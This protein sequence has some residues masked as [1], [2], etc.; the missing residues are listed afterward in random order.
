MEN[1][2]DR[3][4]IQERLKNGQGENERLSETISEITYYYA[5][6]L[7][8]G[9]ILRISRTRKSVWATVF[10]TIPYFV[11]I[12]AIILVLAIF[13]VRKLTEKDHR[14]VE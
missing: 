7:D 9:K 8:D 4:E 2:L 11:L 5:V 6:K 13:L 14:S 1:H 10:S 12:I 3:P